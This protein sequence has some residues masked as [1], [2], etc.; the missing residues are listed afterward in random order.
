MVHW[1]H[2]LAESLPQLHNLNGNKLKKVILTETTFSVEFSVTQLSYKTN[3]K[4]MLCNTVHI[5]IL[6][7]G[8]MTKN[9]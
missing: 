7:C 9:V 8:S 5:G 2:N 6:R 1:N 3:Y 4:D